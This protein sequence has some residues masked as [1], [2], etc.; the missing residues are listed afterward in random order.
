MKETH[1]LYSNI[2]R[3]HTKVTHL[4]ILLV[5]LNFEHYKRGGSLV[6]RYNGMKVTFTEKILVGR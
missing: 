2:K 1:K 6:T 3:I 4:M 5:V